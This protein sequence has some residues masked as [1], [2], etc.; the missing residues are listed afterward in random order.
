VVFPSMV[1]QMIE[2]GEQTGAMDSMLNKIAAFYEDEVE[3]AVSAIT[4]AIEPAMMVF[5]GGIV[6][7]ILIAMYLPIFTMAG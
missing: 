3:A 4:S 2:V 1:V 6:G 5:M 7:W